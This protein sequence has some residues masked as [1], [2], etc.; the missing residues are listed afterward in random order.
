M[1]K[2]TLLIIVVLV[3][4]LAIAIFNYSYQKRIS[5]HPDELKKRVQAIFQEQNVTELSK[6]TFLVSLKHKYGCSY[7]K[8]LYLLGKAREMGLVENEGKNVHLIER[9]V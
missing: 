4:L 5:F 6:T 3:V 8:A 2:I 7:K 9:D 1:T